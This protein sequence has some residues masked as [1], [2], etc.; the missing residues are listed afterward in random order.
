M[1]QGLSRRGFLA[2]VSALSARG[3]LRARKPEL[4]PY[5]PSFLHPNDRWV[6]LASDQPDGGGDPLY[7][8]L[9]LETGACI[10]TLE[11]SGRVTDYGHARIRFDPS[12]RYAVGT[13][14]GEW[15]DVLQRWDLQHPGPALRFPGEGD[16]LPLP[17]LP[18]PGG[19]IRMPLQDY[20]L[21]AF[22]LLR[23]RKVPLKASGSGEDGPSRIAS[24]SGKVWQLTWPKGQNYTGVLERGP[25]HLTFTSW[26]M[27]Y[28]PN[29]SMFADSSLRLA[30]R[31]TQD[32]V[33]VTSGSCT[34]REVDA[35]SGKVLRTLSGAMPQTGLVAFGSTRS[36]IYAARPLDGP[37]LWDRNRPEGSPDI[38]PDGTQYGTLPFRKLGPSP[39]PDSALSVRSLAA[40][41]SSL[42]LG[43]DD[44]RILLGDRQN[45]SGGPWRTL[46]SH[47]KAVRGLAFL[48]DQPLLASGSRDG[49]L[50]VWDLTGSSL[51]R[52][53]PSHDARVN[54]LSPGPGGLL[55]SCGPDG[56]RIWDVLNGKLTRH[57]ATDG[58]WVSDVVLDPKGRWV[59]GA[60]LDGSTRQWDLGTGALLWRFEGD[61]GWCACLA[62]QEE[63][64][65]LA[66]GYELGVL[67][68][69][70][71]T[72]GR[73]LKRTRVDGKGAG[74]APAVH[75]LA[76]S[77][78]GQALA[79]AFGDAVRVY[80][81][82]LVSGQ[83][84]SWRLPL[85][86][87]DFYT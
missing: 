62:Y 42:V 75:A 35:T 72:D 85:D 82:N 5:E 12:G 33:L 84:S 11:G 40:G 56:I 24:R 55:A 77:H 73:P 63:K 49:S 22:S 27:L 48:K 61:Q 31:R 46:G 45:A 28:Q 60:L 64:G 3:L 14:Y 38:D 4:P 10:L 7:E 13:S 83:G 29:T 32:T 43:L 1:G 47:A 65:L 53:L 18:E 70:D 71:P 25:L 39:A 34:V 21:A 6:A 19:F 15:W 26:P 58:V 54:A 2:L 67:R 59:T 57:I 20:D 23:T 80:E 87:G 86:A 81:P 79:A 68:L 37:V 17:D 16:N 44:G 36:L 69:L 41:P 51:V 52:D 30:R 50:K 9:D 76:W 78:D 74:Q 66:V 8:V